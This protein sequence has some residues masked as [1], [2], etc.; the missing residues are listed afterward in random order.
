[1]ELNVCPECFGNTALKRRLVEIRPSFP[2]RERCDFHP[3]RKAVPLDEVG[4]IVQ[5]ALRA[6]Y[7]IGEWRFDEY[8]GDDLYTVVRDTT[9]AED[10][11]VAEGLADWLVANDFYWPQ[12][13][14][15]PFFH[16]DQAYVRMRIEG[17]HHSSLWRRFRESILHRQRFF[18]GPAK[19]F[20][21]EI[22]EGV[23]NQSDVE[24]KPAFYRLETEPE[25]VL[26]RARIVSDEA[27]FAEIA[28][29]PAKLMGPPPPGMRRA[30][31]MNAAGIA[32]FY[33]ANEKETAVAELRPAVGSLISVATFRIRQPIHVLDFSRFKGPG[34]RL[35][36]FAK[37]QA[38]RAAQWSFMLSFASE[39]SQ[40][41][42]PG[43]EHLEYVPAQVVAEYLTNQPLPWHGEEV[44][45]NAIIFRSAQRM[46]GRNI[47]IMGDAGRV[48]AVTTGPPERATAKRHDE[49]DLLAFP[50]P[51]PKTA[52]AGL[53]YVEGSLELLLIGS[54]T[55]TL[56]NQR[57]PVAPTADDLD[58]NEPDY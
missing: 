52:A 2:D 17:Y 22:F 48:V 6:N 55:Y 11:A 16:T 3:R 49:T 45:A 10:D 37:N 42:L 44:T 50:S 43:D 29:D 36:I 18:N 58:A 33:G 35:D 46:G 32:V 51:I 40:P 8:E 21:A 38:A 19:D 14:G 34:R 39:I 23:Q 13:G 57:V 41:I 12:D 31:R 47:A 20:L 4:R 5:P 53:E 9:E 15:Q 30:G 26:Y 28:K 27:A 24:N 54:A 7:A 56:S 1:M 25:T